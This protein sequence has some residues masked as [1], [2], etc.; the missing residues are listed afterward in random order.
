MQ[1]RSGGAAFTRSIDNPLPIETYLNVAGT[2]RH[3]EPAPIA[4]IEAQTKI[5][6]EGAMRFVKKREEGCGV[7]DPAG[8]RG[9]VG[10]RT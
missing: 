7:F 8:I 10:S 9:A 2:Y 3:L 6:L 4:R 5:D 1:P